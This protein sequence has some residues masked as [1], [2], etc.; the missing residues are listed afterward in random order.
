MSIQHLCNPLDS[1]AKLNVQC[2]TIQCNNVFSSGQLSGDHVGC[3]SIN[4]GAM[5]AS[6][7]ILS[8]VIINTSNGALIAGNPADVMITGKIGFVTTSGL[9]NLKIVREDT[10]VQLLRNYTLQFQAVINANTQ[11]LQFDMTPF[12]NMETIFLQNVYAYRTDVKNNTYWG[13]VFTHTVSPGVVVFRVIIDMG[14]LVNY[15]SPYNF[16]INFTTSIYK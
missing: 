10:A 11:Y 4:T 5:V 16:S 3:S 1:E 2:A 7:S 12:S 9:Y 13:N 15:N 8:P 14:Y 6:T